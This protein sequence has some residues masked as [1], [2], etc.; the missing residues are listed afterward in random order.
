MLLTHLRKARLQ[1][2][3]LSALDLVTI[4]VSAIGF[5]EFD[6]DARKDEP[7]PKAEGADVPKPGKAVGADA[8]AGAMKEANGLPPA[9]F[10]KL[11]PEDFW[12]GAGGGAVSLT[13]AKMPAPLAPAPMPS[14]AT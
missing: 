3:I 4:G 9:G 13:F 6:G 1:A 8:G 10:G 12:P 5:V 7:P 11:N 2:S 14:I